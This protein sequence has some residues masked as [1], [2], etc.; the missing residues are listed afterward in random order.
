MLY[1]IAASPCF[2]H[3]YHN[4]P[5]A[6]CY[7]T[8][9]HPNHAVYSGCMEPLLSVNQLAEILGLRPITIYEWVQARKIPFVKLGKRVLFRP[10][11]IESFIESNRVSYRTNVINRKKTNTSA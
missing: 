9:P 2:F 6:E 1:N 5:K 3:T 8:F 10:K 11:D 7:I 4:P